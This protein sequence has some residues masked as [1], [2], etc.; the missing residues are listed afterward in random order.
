L[1]LIRALHAVV[2]CGARTLSGLLGASVDDAPGVPHDEPKRAVPVAPEAAVLVVDD[3]GGQTPVTDQRQTVGFALDGQSY[4]IDLSD[5]DAADFRLALQPYVLSGRRATRRTGAPPVPRGSTP[6]RRS[7]AASRQ[8]GN[9]A[10]R[11]WARANGHEVSDRGRVP[12]NVVQAYQAS[13]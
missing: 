9:A 13:N 3:L 8:E 7:T 1:L 6:V 5:Q 12:M 4:E 10:I 11:K 2:T